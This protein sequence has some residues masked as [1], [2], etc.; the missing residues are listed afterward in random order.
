MDRVFVNAH[1]KFYVSDHPL[2]PTADMEKNFPSPAMLK[3]LMEEKFPITEEE[4][5][6]KIN[7]QFGG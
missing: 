7:L 1:G 6:R 4:L 3:I 5:T 2:D